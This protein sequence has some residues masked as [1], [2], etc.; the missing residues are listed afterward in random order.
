MADRS[1]LLISGPNLN[2][3]GEREPDVY[4][5]DTLDVVVGEAVSAAADLGLHVT[6]AHSNSSSEIVDLIQSARGVHAAIII[7]PGAF[8]H[9]AWSIHDALRTFSGPIV[10][11]H[12]TDPRRRES[13]RS[14]SV[15]APVANGTIAGFGRRGYR[16]AVQAVAAL[17]G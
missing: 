2:L 5:S 17:L 15:V 14:S 16:L 9:Y 12:L 11:V 6:H 10:E 7:N 4:G 8:T 3:L 13:W 1:V